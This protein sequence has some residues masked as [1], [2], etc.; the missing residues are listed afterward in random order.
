MF[1]LFSNELQK[2]P[3]TPRDMNA[4]WTAVILPQLVLMR[5]LIGMNVRPKAFLDRESNRLGFEPVTIL[6]WLR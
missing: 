6:D 5:G 1:S 4:T 3:A 2:V